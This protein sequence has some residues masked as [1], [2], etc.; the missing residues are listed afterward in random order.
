MRKL[1]D[2]IVENYRIAHVPA[3]TSSP[4]EVAKALAVG[5]SA[6]TPRMP[7]AIPSSLRSQLTPS[8][9]RMGIRRFTRLADAFS[10]TVEDWDEAQNQPAPAR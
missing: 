7:P 3:A 2:K 4:A 5:Q 8:I 9:T 6:S 1:K 10:K